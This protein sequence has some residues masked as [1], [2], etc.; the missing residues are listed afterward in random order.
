MRWL[1][2]GDPGGR[3]LV[4]L[5]AFPL[6]ADMWRPQLDAVPAGWRLIAP[7]LAGFG[8]TADHDGVPEIGDFA[9]DIDALADHLRLERFVLGGLSMGGYA[10]FA[11]LRLNAARVTG[12][13]LADTKSGADTLAAREG[14]QKMLDLVASKGVAAVADEML[15]K[16]LGPTTLKSDPAL[17]ARVRAL[18]EGNSPDG[19]SR[20][21]KRLRDRPDSTPLLAAVSVPALVVVGE[22]D[23]ITPVGEARAIAAALPEATLAV[24]PRAGHL[25]NLEAS[26]AFAAALTPW[27]AGL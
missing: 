2:A 24:L 21:I 19:V 25:S 13:V 1:E 11:Y 9:R 23:G 3:P 14:R 17:A 6:G 15:P 27:L 22:E 12:V 10:V 16:L 20:A 7:D 26:D 4:W 18:I 5:H 8:G